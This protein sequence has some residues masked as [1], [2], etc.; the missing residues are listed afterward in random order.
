MVQF[1]AEKAL[2]I[3]GSSSRG[4]MAQLQP[5]TEALCAR[6]LPAPRG[7]PHAASSSDRCYKLPGLAKRVGPAVKSLLLNTLGG[8]EL[9]RYE[10]TAQEW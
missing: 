6:E 5:S 9:E 1:I 4:P 2:D 7:G 8:G 3:I 10:L